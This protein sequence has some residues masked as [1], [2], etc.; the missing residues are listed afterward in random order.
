LF[1][2]K[3]DEYGESTWHNTFL[4]LKS[5]EFPNV[6]KCEAMPVRFFGPPRRKVS[7][8]SPSDARSRRPAIGHP[9]GLIP[10]VDPLEQTRGIWMV[11]NSNTKLSRLVACYALGARRSCQA[12]MLRPT[13]AT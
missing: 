4:H 5:L 3:T 13:M 1:L 6:G 12:P 8:S 2:Q 10:S 7:M 9:I 11:R